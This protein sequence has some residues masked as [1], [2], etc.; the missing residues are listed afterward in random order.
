MNYYLSIGSNI[1]ERRRYILLALAGLQKL[2]HLAQCSS[3]YESAPLGE[4]R[5]PLFYNLVCELQSP[6]RPFR[7]LRKIKA[8]EVQIGRQRRYRWGPREVDIDL[9]EWSGKTIYSPV[10]NLPHKE[11]EKR[12][13]VLVPLREIAPDF[14]N[15]ALRDIGQIIRRCPR[16][17]SIHRIEPIAF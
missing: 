12:L 9:I 8:L 3:L 7:L 13:F 2:G 6:L 1:G 14:R 5:Q 16:Q 11:M 4:T 15:R 17:G 10:L